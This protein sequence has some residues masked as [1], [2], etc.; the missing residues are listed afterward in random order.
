MRTKKILRFFL[1]LLGI[2]SLLVVLA[3]ANK[4]IDEVR[5]KQISISINHDDESAFI[6][7]LEVAK[8]IQESGKQ[9][10]NQQFGLINTAGLEQL[11]NN[12]THIKVAEVYRNY[13]GELHLNIKSRRA[14][15]RVINAQGE[16]FYLDEDGDLMKWSP[17]YTARVP[18]F[19]GRIFESYDRFYMINFNRDDINDSLLIKMNLY[20]IYRLARYIDSNEFWKSQ[21]EQINI[22]KEVELI[23][24]IGSHTIVFGDFS[25]LDEKFNKLMVFYREGLNKMGWNLYKT[26][27][28]KY[29]N[30]VVCTKVPSDQLPRITAS[31][32][33]N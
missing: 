12:H 33:T 25:E 27:N 24:M 19:T 16:S 3:F 5:C 11:L 26:I 17:L 31:T 15:A 30:Q 2:S 6:D 28:L 4:S 10:V 9:Y 1:W 20:G 22:D 13:D 29:K 32:S 21:I 18:V 23:P 7:S 8:L 14:I